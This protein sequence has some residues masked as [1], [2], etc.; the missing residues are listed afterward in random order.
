MSNVI[1]LHT[2][3]LARADGAAYVA[4]LISARLGLDAQR[5]ARLVASTRAL[6]CAGRS[7][8][9]AVRVAHRNARA[10][11]RAPKHA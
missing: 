1:P 6:V 8:A 3:P 2:N 5:A 7:A 10:L 11:S 9:Y 4:R